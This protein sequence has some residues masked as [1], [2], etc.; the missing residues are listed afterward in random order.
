M[1]IEFVDGVVGA[2]VVEKAIPVGEDGKHLN[3]AELG[4]WRGH[5]NAIQECVDAL[6]C[7]CCRFWQVLLINYQL[8]AELSAE[9][10][11]QH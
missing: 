8:P 3:G 9:T 10:C 2:N 7:Y 5:M 6:L 11:H 4:C 1:D